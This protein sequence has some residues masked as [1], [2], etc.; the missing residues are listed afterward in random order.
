MRFK[1]YKEMVLESLL[2]L[3]PNK[4]IF[5]EKMKYNLAV[6]LY[7]LQSP[8][9]PFHFEN[10]DSKHSIILTKQVHEI[11]LVI[12]NYNFRNQKEVPFILYGKMT[13]GGAIVFDDIDCD[14]KKLSDDSASFQN[15]NEYLNLKLRRFIL[16]DEKNKIICLG[17]THPYTGD[18]VS[19]SYSLMDLIIHL[20][21]NDNQVF[22]NPKNNNKVFSLMKS[23]TKDFNFIYYEV[24]QNRFYKVNKVFLQTKRK[25]FEPLSAYNYCEE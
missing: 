10:L 7:V 19:F 15:L 17:H 9:N 2:V 6:P 22:L 16:D 18:K 4:D 12:D 11:L 14:F 5:Y 3:D 21:L 13:K 20:Q 1:K 23:I 24:E 8:V 25:E